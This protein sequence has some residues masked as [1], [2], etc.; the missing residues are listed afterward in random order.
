MGLAAVYGTIKNH[1]G[2]INVYSE[3]GHGTTFNV[4]LPLAQSA[5]K[6]LDGATG[7]VP[8][9]GTASILVV[10]DEEIVRKLTARMLQRL[11]YK[12][13]VCKDGAEGVEYYRKAWE[14]VDLVILDMIMPKLDGRD[15]FIAMRK[16]NPD[17]KAILS[18]GYGL[19]A[20]AQSILDE[21]VRRFLQK[22]FQIATLSQVV[23]DVLGR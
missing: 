1:Q 5:V 10:D 11:G 22:P 21:G 18:S 19:N 14:Q 17:I 7:A 15:T 2:A 13:A 6:E 16:I 4:Y 8:V 12:V 23:V 3:V 9:K 20:E